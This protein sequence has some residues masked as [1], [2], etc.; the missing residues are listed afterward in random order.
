MIKKKLNIKVNSIIAKSLPKT[1]DIDNYVYLMF[2]DT[3]NLLPTYIN[4]SLKQIEE[5]LL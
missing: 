3:Y 1:S 4:L 5:F 2:K